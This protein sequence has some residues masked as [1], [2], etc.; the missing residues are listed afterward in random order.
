MHVFRVS[1]AM[2]AVLTTQLPSLA[3]DVTTRSLPLI[4]SET[5]VASCGNRLVVRAG[6]GGVLSTDAS[7]RSARVGGATGVSLVFTGNHARCLALNSAQG[8][9]DVTGAT[10]K[11]VFEPRG[12]L[13]NSITAATQAADDSVWIGIA[14]SE[15]VAVFAPDGSV[16]YFDLPH[17]GLG[18][19]TLAPAEPRFP[20]SVSATPLFASELQSLAASPGYV[21]GLRTTIPAGDASPSYLIRIDPATQ[22]Y[23]RIVLDTNRRGAGLAALGDDSAVVLMSNDRILVTDSARILL[24]W[25]IPGTPRYATPP[26]SLNL[27]VPFGDGAD[28]VSL[29]DGTLWHVSVPGQTIELKARFPGR[30]SWLTVLSDRFAAVNSD[31]SELMTITFRSAMQ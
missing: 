12:T 14:G 3:E 1:V 31:A 8:L 20:P 5:S 28:V 4:P 22:A 6:D 15:Q 25:E 13:P 26:W 10:A 27:A 18:N 30:P 29:K 21:W 16:R 7:G 11:V 23:S 24:R 9:L 2:L 19:G 17:D